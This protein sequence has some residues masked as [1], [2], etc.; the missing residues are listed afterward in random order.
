[1]PQFSEEQ[2]MIAMV[3]MHGP[4]TVEELNKQLNIPFNKMMDEIRG[5]LQAGVLEKDGYPT[6]YKLKKKIYEEIVKRKQIAETDSNKLRIRAF[7]E[8][9]AIEQELLEKQAKKLE[10]VLQKDKNFTVYSLEKAPIEKTGEYYSTYFELN[11]S[12]KDFASL[13]RFMF[14]F[15][16]SSVEVVKPPKIEFTA[17]DLQDGLIEIAEM[18]QKYSNYIQRLLNKQ[19][20]EKFYQDLYK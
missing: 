12:V 8:M 14:F 20:L 16:P 4:R 3:L 19:E 7:I 17:R 9:Q 13:V 6:K 2:K 11:F 1:M 10:E 18:A 15:G 5:M